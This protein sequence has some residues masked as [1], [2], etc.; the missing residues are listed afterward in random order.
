MK[1]H[2]DVILIGM[3]IL[4]LVLGMAFILLHQVYYTRHERRKQE[5][6]YEEAERLKCLEDP[7]HFF[8][9]YFLID[10]NPATTRYSRE[11]FNKIWFDLI[12]YPTGYAIGSGRRR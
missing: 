5:L 2:L 3:L 10:G 1:E 9:N 4:G 8:V 11:E 7:Y 6:E 12:N